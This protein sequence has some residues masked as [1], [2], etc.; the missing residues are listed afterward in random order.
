MSTRVVYLLA[1]LLMLTPRTSAADP[2]GLRAPQIPVSGTGLQD[3]L[4]SVGE[5]IDV[6]HAQV[7]AQLMEMYYLTN[8]TYTIQLE[9]GLKEPGLSLGLYDGSTLTDSFVELFPAAAGPGWFAVASFRTAPTRVVVNL[10]DSDAALVSTRTTLGAN[11]RAIG[12]FVQGPDGVFYSQDARNPGSAAQVLFYAGTG[13]NTGSVWIAFE[14][15][16]RA[17]GADGDFDDAVVFLERNDFVGP[18]HR[19]SWGTLKAR[20]R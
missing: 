12:F 20:F 10:F 13:V 7:D 17:N 6:Q 15:G 3:Y 2:Y 11:R 8:S 19:T 4:N 9:V 14:A 16:A 1:L 5:L 18:V